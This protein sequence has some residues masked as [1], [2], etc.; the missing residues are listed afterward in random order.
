MAKKRIFTLILTVL[1]ILSLV[2]VPAMASVKTAVH[3]MGTAVSQEPVSVTKIKVKGTSITSLTKKAAKMTV[4]W[5]KQSAKIK[6]KR[7]SGYQVQIA[8]DQNFTKNRKS[9]RIKDYR[10]TKTTF[11][12]L[13]KNKK[14]YARVRTCFRSGGTTYYSEWSK[15]KSAKDKQKP[16]P[17]PEPTPAPNP[18]HELVYNQNDFELADMLYGSS[19]DGN[20]IVSP[21]SVNLVLAMMLQGANGEAQ[22]DLENYL[23]V[24]KENVGVYAAALMQGAFT[25]QNSGNTTTINNAFWYNTG[26]RIDEAYL[27]AVSNTFK[28]TFA[29]LNFEDTGHAADVINGWCYENT[30]GL[31]PSIVTEEMLQDIKDV[32]ANT[33]Y[34]KNS[35]LEQVEEGMVREGEFTGFDRKKQTVTYLHSDERIAYENE[36][37]IAFEKRFEDKYTFIGILPKTEGEFTLKNLDIQ[38]LLTNRKTDYNHVYVTMP[39]FTLESGGEITDYLQALGIRTP[40]TPAADFGGIS[41]FE[42]IMFTRV[43]HKTKMILDETGVEAAA[44]TAAMAKESAIPMQEKILKIELTR[45]YAFLIMDTETGNVLFLGKITNPAG[46]AL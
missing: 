20:S 29:E 39:K 23:G 38:S 19:E 3:S 25:D 35:W 41:P 44:A 27:D 36:Q 40:F 11:T 17:E 31:I 6:G 8:T 7:I 14:Y 10:S 37:A 1:M 28:G 32:L 13:K 4:K 2:S 42:P 16:T 21:T 15:V 26:Q 5:K 43:V 45:P 46:S 30:N 18:N 24:K 12:N 34:F 33:V 22:N 9:V